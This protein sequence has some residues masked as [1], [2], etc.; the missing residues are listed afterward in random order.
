M[1]ELVRR[2]E[3][4]NMLDQ[5]FIS[6]V[7]IKILKLFLTNPDDRY[8]VREIQ[9]AVDEEINAVRRELSRLL[10]IKLLTNE[11]RSNR[12]YYQVRTDFPLYD[13]LLG[14]VAKEHSLG[15]RLLEQASKLG[16]VK[17]AYISRSFALGNPAGDQ[18]VDL[19]IIG[20]VALDKV[21]R[22]VK[23][24]EARLGHEINYTVMNEEEL[25]LRKDRKDR[26]LMRAF[27]QGKIML[28]GDEDE[29]MR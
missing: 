10:E 9:R 11:Q 22:F 26:F 6:K 18:D 2:E 8:Y 16:K 15:K 13:E 19:V 27:L 4:K 14:M 7:R 5:L 1:G 21:R 3:I 28:I 12:L 20:D 17:Y 24:E 25:E 23:E 29:M